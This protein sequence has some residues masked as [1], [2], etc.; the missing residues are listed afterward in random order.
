M[1]ALLNQWYDIG[2]IR[3]IMPLPGGYGGSVYSVVSDNGEFILKDIDQN[4]MNHPENEGRILETLRLAGLPVARI[5]PTKEGEPVVRQGGHVYHLQTR[6]QGNSCQRNTAPEWLLYELGHTLGKI[7]F[8]MGSLDPLPTGMGQGFFDYVTPERAIRSHQAT[9]EQAL[10]CGHTETIRAIQYKM[11]LLESYPDIKFDLSQLTC[12]NTHG[13]FKLQQVIS[14]DNRINGIIDFTS[15]CFHPMCWELIRSYLSADPDCA[16]GKLHIGH[17]QRYV[18]RFLE[19]GRLNSLDIK[20][21]PQLYYYQILTSDY[22]AQYYRTDSSSK[23]EL[24]EDAFLTFK[25]CIW[26]EQ[27]IT[28]L[29]NVLTASF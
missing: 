17:F 27:N 11:R 9:L 22:F 8:H 4:G 15:A 5:C 1:K 16:E 7:Q 6:I 28:R 24:L 29:E 21:M 18:S 23:C 10:A 14:G 26:F 3:S 20:L 19:Y 25:Q 13:D 2:H 12:C